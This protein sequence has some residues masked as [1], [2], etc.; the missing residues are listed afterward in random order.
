MAIDGT[1]F[2]VP[3]TR[4]NAGLFGYPG[5]PKETYP[6]FPK[7]RLVFLVEAGTHLIIY[8]FCCSYGMGEKRNALKLL[9]SI[10]SSILL[11]CDRG[12][13]SFKMVHAVIKQQGFF[14]GRLPA[15][16]KFEVVKTL[17]DGSYLSWIALDGVSR[18]KGAKRISVHIIEYVIEDNGTL[19]TYRLIT[20]LIDVAKFPALILAQDSHH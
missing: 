20:N 1:V 4:T 3:D 9:R 10:N 7:V 14:P 16:F 6:A 13:H 18:K 17:T 12:L 19:K 11:M 2:D 5:S 8:A 15:Y